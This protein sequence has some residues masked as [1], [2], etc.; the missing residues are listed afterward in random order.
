MY[1]FNFEYFVAAADSCEYDCLSKPVWERELFGG[2]KK[3][4][5][6]LLSRINAIAAANIMKDIIVIPQ[7]HFHALKGNM[8]DLFAID[9]KSRRDKWRIIIC[10]LDEN[11]EKFNPCHIDEIANVAKIVRVEEV[12][13]HYE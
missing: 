12:S 13:A 4:A 11:E 6:S 10:P 1:V 2:D 5:I 9:V 8:K 7:F 3:L